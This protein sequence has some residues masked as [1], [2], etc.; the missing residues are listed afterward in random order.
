MNHQPAGGAH[1]IHSGT[2][3][4]PAHRRLPFCRPV[5]GASAPAAA[6]SRVPLLAAHTPAPRRPHSPTALQLW[7]AAQ[8][9]NFKFVPPSQ[10]ILYVNAVYIGWVSI[11]VRARV[12]R[13]PT[14]PRVCVASPPASCQRHADAQRQIEGCSR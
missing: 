5:A 11:L 13:T 9:I 10:R 7:P 2:R 3:S 6:W 8:L 1:V 4:A 12:V 14:Q